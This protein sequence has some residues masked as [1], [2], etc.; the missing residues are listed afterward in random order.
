MPQNEPQSGSLFDSPAISAPLYSEQFTEPSEEQ[1]DQVAEA[2]IEPEGEGQEFTPEEAPD[3]WP[4]ELRSQWD[5][6]EKRRIGDYTRKTQ[7]LAEA[8]KAFESEQ[9]GLAAKAGQYD[10]LMNNPELLRKQLGI[11][12]PSAAPAQP[13]QAPGE[14]INPRD[15]LQEPAHDAIEHMIRERVESALGQFRDNEL[16]AMDQYKGYIDTLAKQN[17]Q[18]DWNELVK[19]YPVA[20]KYENQVAQWV[21]THKEA[22]L[23]QAFFA[24]AQDAAVPVAKAPKPGLLKDEEPSGAAPDSR[25]RAQL[26]S[27]SSLPHGKTTPHD[28]PARLVDAMLQVAKENGVR[29]NQY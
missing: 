3:H 6:A 8:R 14:A 11:P 13:A 20:E 21:Q 24:V 5:E 10:L 29:F 23:K 7:T 26:P 9:S 17:I 27:K 4:D 2:E 18:R 28:K 25:R 22:D 15:V 12:D 19:Q 16:G 1:Q